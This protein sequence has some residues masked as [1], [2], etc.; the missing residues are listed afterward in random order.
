MQTLVKQWEKLIQKMSSKFTKLQ[1]TVGEVNQ[2]NLGLQSHIKKLE[3][4]N[5]I[6][7]R[8]L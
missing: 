7:E 5:A 6:L 4:K 3:S 8:R 2:R 1:E